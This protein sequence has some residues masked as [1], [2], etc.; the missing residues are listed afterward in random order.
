MSLKNLAAIRHGEMAPYKHD[1]GNV[2][3]WHLRSNDRT[4]F[5]QS[6]VCRAEEITDTLIRTRDWRHAFHDDR[7][8]RVRFALESNNSLR[9]LLREAE[10]LI[11]N[12]KRFR[13]DDGEPLL[14]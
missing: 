6:V 13:H 11:E 7:D 5:C 2:A 12:L 10:K 3:D 1:S 4:D 14:V 9:G 8:S